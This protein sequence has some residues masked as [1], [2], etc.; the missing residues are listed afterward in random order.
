MSKGLYTYFKGAQSL[1]GSVYRT[2]LLTF[3]SN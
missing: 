1:T 2:H 3:H